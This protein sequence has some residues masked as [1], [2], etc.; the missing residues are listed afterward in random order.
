MSPRRPPAPRPPPAPTRRRARV[1][2]SQGFAP[3][4]ALDELLRAAAAVR[5]HAHA[6]YSRFPVGAAVR[7]AGRVYVGCNVENS[8]FP[9]CVCAERNAIAAAIAGGARRIEAIAVVAGSRRPGPPCGGCRQVLS[10][11]CAA[12]TPVVYASA[13]GDRVETTVGAL[14]P[15]AFGG[16]DLG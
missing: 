9:L 12:G 11:F 10:E 4:G 5:G 6:P 2:A 14:L 1:H 3:A 8:S 13:R 15:Q 16:D 7:A